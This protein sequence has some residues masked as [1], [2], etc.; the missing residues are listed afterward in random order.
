MSRAIN[1][2]L[3]ALAE[4]Q[5]SVG[6]ETSIGE[7]AALPGRF[8]LLPNYP[9]PFNAE[10][11]IGFRLG[12]ETDLTLRIFDAV[13]R[14]VRQLTVGRFS[15]GTF[16]LAWDGQDDGG[17]QVASGIYFYHLNS[18]DHYETRSMVLLR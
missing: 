8:A 6:T 12:A 9:N 10:T 7:Q 11:I 14:S 3:T 13:G 16:E 2:S 17:H 1:A 15:P 5:N 4:S 18:S